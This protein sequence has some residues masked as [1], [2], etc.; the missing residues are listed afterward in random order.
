MADNDAVD[1][2]AASEATGATDKTGSTAAA[3]GAAVDLLAGLLKRWQAASISGKF[4]IFAGLLA[5][6]V[7]AYLVVGWVGWTIGI[8]SLKSLADSYASEVAEYIP[9]SQPLLKALSYLIFLVMLPTGILFV[10]LKSKSRLHGVILFAV[11]MI[12]FNL[13]LGLA[14]R[15]FKVNPLTGGPVKC[16][17]INNGKPLFYDL[18]PG[19]EFQIDPLT[20]RK[21]I[22]V[23]PELAVKLSRD[24]PRLIPSGSQTDFFDRAMGTPRTW[25]AK[26][27]DGTIELF[28]NDGFH[29]ITSEELQPIT[30]EIAVEWQRQYD[31]KVEQQLRDEE[32]KKE[33]AEATKAEEARLAEE[34]R[35]EE[36]RVAEAKRIEEARIAEEKRL[37]EM[38][39]AEEKR[40]EEQRLAEENARRMQAEED[41]RL[42]QQRREEQERQQAEEERARGGRRCDQLAGN[43][44]DQDRNTAFPGVPYD[45]LVAHAKDAILACR[46]AVSIDGDTLRYHYQ[47]ARALQS[48]RSGEAEDILQMLADKDYAAAFDNLGWIQI[49]K[50]NGRQGILD[51]ERGAQLGGIESM[52]SL[53]G[54]LY[55]GRLVQ[56]DKQAGVN[57]LRMAAERGHSGATKLVSKIKEGELAGEVFGT[58]FGTILGEALKRR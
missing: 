38:R 44:Y 28:D 24:P 18:V 5:A 4:A 6:L 13:F 29:P 42:E 27:P 40:A 55:E 45:L 10:S 34:R 51:F 36:I 25:F 54:F 43:A 56:K 37:E 32:L 22:P 19:K 21:C 41:A 3:S 57:Y 52:F 9:L 53:G 58:V 35:L 47:L 50:G 46:N 20:G 2:K 33:I 1:T 12:V 14:A 49:N 39:I 8:F 31:Q 15:N 11:S 26:L 7:L 17:V 16:V 30:P 23:T 48:Q